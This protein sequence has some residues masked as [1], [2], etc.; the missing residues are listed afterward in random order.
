MR[1][2]LANATVAKYPQGGGHWNWFLQYSLG[3]RELGHNVFWLEVVQATDDREHDLAL[4][5]SFL[6]RIPAYGLDGRAIVA[7]APKTPLGVLDEAEIYGGT[8]RR[9]LQLTR[10]ADLLWNFW[11]GLK[12][13]LL[14]E[15]RRRAFID[16]DPGHLQVCAATAEA[17]AIG[18][19]DSYLTVGA[20]IHQPDCGIPTLGYKWNSFKPF[21]YL[22]AYEIA[23]DP[24]LRAPFTS[25]TH[26]TWE[27]LHFHKR[28][29]SVSKRTAYMRYVNLPRYADRPFELSVD[30]PPDDEV[31]L[32]S[33]GWEIVSPAQVARSPEQYREY[34]RRS[35]A[36]F[37]CP[38]PI[39]ID[40][41]TGWFSD[42][43]VAYLASG[44]PVLAE[45]TGF[46]ENLP[47]G[48]GLI[49]FS[50]ID[51]AL[52]GIAEIDGNYAKHRRAARKIAEEIF[53]SRKCLNAM[54]GACGA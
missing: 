27:E 43:S 16:V 17:F 11:F 26:W 48:S 32:R 51:E 22:P 21:A 29:L 24:G 28:V 8:A 34:I 7:L 13:P 45:D 36:E 39:H 9:I 49:A 18:D 23:A 14:N 41:K 33:S 6:E 30:L 54:L 15:F 19:H 50:D 2:V 10:E 44:R 4:I 31:L 12:A 25:I 3:L 52:A 40:L 47:T 37:L 38:K 35:R 53:D 42:R 5:R 46:S 20:R 1:I